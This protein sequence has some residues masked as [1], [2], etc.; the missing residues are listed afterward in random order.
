MTQE[1]TLLIVDDSEAIRSRVK[2]ILRE[3]GLFATY[4]TA[5]DGVEGFRALLTNHVDLI[6]C[7]LV[8][9][10]IDGFKFLS[11]KQSKAEYSEVPV[12]MLTGEEDVG[13]KVRGLDAGASDYL[14]KPFNDAELVARVRVHLKLKAL[15]DELREKN[16]RLENISRTDELTELNN[17]RHFMDLLRAEFLRAQRYEQQ[18]VYSMADIDHFKRIND[19]HGHLIGDRALVSVADVLRNTVRGQDI[20]GRYGGEE[21]GIGMPHTDLV[22]AYNALERC[23]KGVETKRLPLGN[24]EVLGATISIGVVAFP[25][26]GVTSVDDLIRCADSALYRAKNQGRNRIVV[27]D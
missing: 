2:H 6:L 20:V 10:G 7:D 13:A 1:R 14:T 8:M 26:A 27:A 9:P 22:G 23:R 11:L 4:I 3:T 25:R 21:F 17:R 19:T 18:L 15:Q 12:I 24:G 5:E 16:A